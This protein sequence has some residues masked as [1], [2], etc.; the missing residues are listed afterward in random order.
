[1][2]AIFSVLDSNGDGQIDLQEILV[3]V[4]GKAD[5]YVE[6]SSLTI[7]DHPNNIYNGL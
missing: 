4:D 1:M 2:N 7:S 5:P 6:G 3:L